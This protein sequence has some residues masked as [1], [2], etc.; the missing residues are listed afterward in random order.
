[1]GRPPG[2]TT[3]QTG[4]SPMRSPGRPTVSREVERRF[5]AKIAEGLSTEDAALACGVSAAVGT[6]WFGEGGGMPPIS[7]A[8]AVEAPLAVCGA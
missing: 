7:L 6:R 4:R 3:A 5:W 8:P 2:W 1:M